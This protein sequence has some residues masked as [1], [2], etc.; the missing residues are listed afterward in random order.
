MNT[1]MN[2]AMDTKVNTIATIAKSMP[3]VGQLEYLRSNLPKD[4]KVVYRGNDLFMLCTKYRNSRFAYPGTIIANVDGKYRVVS[5][6]AAPPCNV[7]GRIKFDKDTK[8]YHADDGTTVTLYWRDEWIVGTHRGYDVREFKWMG[9]KYSDV[10]G[11][12][13]KACGFDTKTLD[14]NVCYTIGFNHPAYHPFGGNT[15]RIPRMWFV[16][17]VNLD[18]F[19][20][21]LSGIINNTTHIPNQERA[22]FSRAGQIVSYARTAL[23]YY[24]RTGNVN[25]GYIVENNGERRFIESSLMGE[26]RRLFYSNKFNNLP[27]GQSRSLFAVVHAFL[28]D[29]SCDTFVILFPQ[30]NHYYNVLNNVTSALRKEAFQYALSRAKKITT[31]IEHEAHR[32]YMKYYGQANMSDF[33]LYIDREIFNPRYASVIYDL[34]FSK[35]ALFVLSDGEKH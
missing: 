16:Q 31:P 5:V 14:K 32:L 25:F 27:E 4:V 21:G 34:A 18:Q 7:R 9:R 19:N 11:E 1:A 3:N 24:R 13:F 20:K 29:A 35:D 12:T 26:I 10:L 28:D 23:S 17:A 30:F 22:Q 8:V 15:D 2:T 6:P 33:A